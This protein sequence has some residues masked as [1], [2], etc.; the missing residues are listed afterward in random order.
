LVSA[1]RVAGVLDGG[2]ARMPGCAASIGLPRRDQRIGNAATAADDRPGQ[3]RRNPGPPSP[4]QILERQLNGERIRFT[5]AD[6]ALL[7]ALLHRLPRTVL[8]QIRLLVRPETVLRWHRDLIA[9]HHAPYLP[10]EAG[11]LT[12]HGPVRPRAGAAPGA[13]ERFLGIPGTTSNSTP[14]TGSRPTAATSNK[15]C[16]RCVACAPTEQ[17][18]LAARASALA[19]AW[20]DEDDT[21]RARVCVLRCRGQ[22]WLVPPS[23]RLGWA[24]AK[25]PRGNR[26]TDVAVAGGRIR[27]AHTALPARLGT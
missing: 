14:T 6:R 22:S 18:K 20:C 1:Y 23:D 27:G 24:M 3:G 19:S 12:A 7:A 4:D 9:A 21:A 11:R 26:Q 2:W 8:R 10:T 25:Q 15:G 13:G 5:A 16:G 17:R